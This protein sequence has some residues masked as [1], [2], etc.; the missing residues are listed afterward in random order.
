MSHVMATSLVAAA[1]IAVFIAIELIFRQRDLREREQEQEVD[2]GKV[3]LSQARIDRRSDI[4]WA[5][6]RER[7][8]G[9]SEQ[10]KSQLMQRINE[11][12]RAEDRSEGEI[13]TSALALVDRLKREMH[14]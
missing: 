14:Q 5:A 2:T 10:Q 13:I 7:M 8:I 9:L 11:L 1:M 6:V 12:A 4:T 3:R